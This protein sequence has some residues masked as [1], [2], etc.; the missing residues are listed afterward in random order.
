MNTFTIKG[1]LIQEYQKQLKELHKLETALSFPILR[2]LS[3]IKAECEKYNQAL[4]DLIHAYVTKDEKGNPKVREGKQGLTIWEFEYTRE[5]LEEAVKEFNAL[6]DTD[7]TLP[8]FKARPDQI[9]DLLKSKVPGNKYYLL[10]DNIIGEAEFE[11]ANTLA[12][13]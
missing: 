12:T 11:E 2:T 7:Y 5:N 8:Y 6:T 9:A 3:L 13:F 10:I 1:A 4:A